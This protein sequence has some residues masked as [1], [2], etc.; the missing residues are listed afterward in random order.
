MLFRN[1]L[2]EVNVKSPFTKKERNEIYLNAFRRLLYAKDYFMCV[3]IGESTEV[4]GT[5]RGGLGFFPELS[6]KEYVR[7]VSSSYDIWFNG[8]DPL[9]TQKRATI[10]YLC[11]LETL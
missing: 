3:A 11:Y 5:F 6:N 10:L 4:I 2:E 1:T 8:N 9:K 7:E